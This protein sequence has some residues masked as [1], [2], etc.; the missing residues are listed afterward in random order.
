LPNK[1]CY[2]ETYRKNQLAPIQK[3]EHKFLIFDFHCELI[4]EDF[5]KSCEVNN[6][7]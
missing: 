4:H 6:A 5:S 2:G 1:S 3:Y 7:L